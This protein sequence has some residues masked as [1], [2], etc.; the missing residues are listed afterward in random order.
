MCIPNHYNTMILLHLIYNVFMDVTWNHQ[1]VSCS[2]CTCL[3]IK[4]NDTDLFTLIPCVFLD[5]TWIRSKFNFLEGGSVMVTYF[6]IIEVYL[7]E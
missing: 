3:Y 6:A 7:K 1:D 4:S 2:N 5:V